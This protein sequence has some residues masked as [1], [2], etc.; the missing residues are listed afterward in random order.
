[1]RLPDFSAMFGADLDDKTA[2]EAATHDW[3]YAVVDPEISAR[4]VLDLLTTKRTFSIA[5]QNTDRWQKG[6]AEN[7]EEFQRTGTLDA[8]TPKYIRPSQYLR[9]DG[10]FIE[11]V[12][13]MFEANWFKLFRAW[14]A[15]RFLSKFDAIYEFGCGSGHNVAWLAQEFPDKKIVGLDWAQASVDILEALRM[16][17]L[18]SAHFDFFK[19]GPFGFDP[20]SAVLTIGALEQTGLRWRPFL[21]FLRHTRPA[22]CF[23]IEPIV[24]WYDPTSLVDHTAIKIHEARG[25]WQGFVNE[26]TPF[27]THRTGFGSLMLEGYSQLQWSPHPMPFPAVDGYV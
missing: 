20:N 16:P 8:L 11:P 9:L 15:R 12:D 13:P 24:E 17:N 23:H 2:L 6:W 25:F 18:Y 5:G 4:I 22:M 1:M 27:R 10:Q 26:I 3:R 7:L 14:F 19:P 21:D